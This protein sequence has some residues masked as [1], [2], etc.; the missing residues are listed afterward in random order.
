MSRW[1]VGFV[2]LLCVVVAA[3]FGVEAAA[4]SRRE[5]AERRPP[6]SEGEA[7]AVYERVMR[8]LAGSEDLRSRQLRNIVLACVG[9]ALIVATPRLSAWITDGEAAIPAWLGWATFG[10]AA[11]VLIS[12]LAIHL[13]GPAVMAMSAIWRAAA[14]TRAEET[15]AHDRWLTHA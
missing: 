3:W 8:A 11:F 6:L 10:A 15:A 14:L 13:L 4:R 9:S 2:T 12:T 5:R 1:V 7:D